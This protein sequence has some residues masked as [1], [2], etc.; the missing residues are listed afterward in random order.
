MGSILML[1]MVAVL[2]IGI[3]F[4][5]W[6]GKPH[7]KND[8]EPQPPSAAVAEP[9]GT[10]VRRKQKLSPETRHFLRVAR[11]TALRKAAMKSRRKAR[12]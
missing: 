8:S 4:L 3:I 2:A 12:Y 1:V 7:Y 9:V 11:D 10:T 6:C 5:M